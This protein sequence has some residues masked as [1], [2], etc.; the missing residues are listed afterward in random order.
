MIVSITSRPKGAAREVVP[1]CTRLSLLGP[2]PC[3]AL[4]ALPI[5][6]PVVPRCAQIGTPAFHTRH[7]FRATLKTGGSGAEGP[8]GVKRGKPSAEGPAGVR[9]GKPSAEGPAGER[10]CVPRETARQAPRAGRR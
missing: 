4:P 8:A 9:K 6:L 1:V 5:A 2:A 10:D 3:A 7:T